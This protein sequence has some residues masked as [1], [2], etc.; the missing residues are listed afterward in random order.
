MARRQGGSKPPPY[1]PWVRGRRGEQ[2]SPGEFGGSAR[3]RG[4]AML[5]PTRVWLPLRGAP[6]GR[7]MRGG[8][9]STTS[10]PDRPSVT[11]G[12]SSPLGEPP[13]TPIILA[14]EGSIGRE[15]KK[16]EE[17]R[18]TPAFFSFFTSRPQLWG[19]KG[20]AALSR[21]L[22]V[23]HERAR[24]A[25]WRRS[26]CAAKRL[27]RNS[28]TFFASFFGHKKGRPNGRIPLKKALPQGRQ[29]R[30]SS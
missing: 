29:G 13:S 17:K 16:R 30:K 23:A 12:D 19:S 21:G 20:R 18:S 26:L 4:R 15:V 14:P 1:T 2:C 9:W 10:T 7:R 11:F 24:F 8:P 25:G 6:V 28:E 27:P 5:A 3:P 22:R